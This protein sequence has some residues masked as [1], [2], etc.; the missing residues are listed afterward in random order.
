MLMR[1]GCAMAVASHLLAVIEPI[2]DTI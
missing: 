1:L 2:N